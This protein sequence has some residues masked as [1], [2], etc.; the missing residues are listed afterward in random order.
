MSR[1]PA[2]W[3]VKNQASKILARE[4]GRGRLAILLGAGTG[5]G[6]LPGWV[7]LVA[8]ICK[9]EGVKPPDDKNQVEAKIQE[10][11]AKLRKEKRLSDYIQAVKKS[12]YSECSITKEELRRHELFSSI[13][14]LLT[15][16]PSG[17]ASTV[18]TYNFDNLLE[19]HL[20]ACGVPCKTIYNLPSWNYNNQV[21]VYHP[22]GFLPRNSDDNSERISFSRKEFAD[23]LRGEPS[24]LWNPLINQIFSSHTLLLI[25]L[26]GDDINLIASLTASQEVHPAFGVDRFPYRGISIRTKPER[27]EFDIIKDEMDTARIATLYVNSYSEL[28]DFLYDICEKAS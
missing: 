17:R 13:R 9:A 21:S 8:K 3:T 24:K 18:L 1:R 19:T 26:S 4:L 10:V 12:L 2:D 15:T 11:K 28:P 5:Y 27:G 6:I 7:D 16:K 20:K 22:H 23:Q 14:T 25:G